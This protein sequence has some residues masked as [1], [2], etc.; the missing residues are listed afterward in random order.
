MP[1]VRMTV[2]GIPCRKFSACGDDIPPEIVPPYENISV[3]QWV[4][5]HYLNLINYSN[6]HYYYLG[7]DYDLTE[8]MTK[9]LYR[10]FGHISESYAPNIKLLRAK[11]YLS[12][13]EKVI[14]CPKNF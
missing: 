2:T 6:G 11:V 13:Y 14:K 8:Y 7:W 12:R 10:Q 4:K 1:S 5:E 9:Y 3:K